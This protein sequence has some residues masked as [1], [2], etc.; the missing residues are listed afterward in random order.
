VVAGDAGTRVVVAGR[1]KD[2]LTAEDSIT[3]LG[4]VDH[5]VFTAAARAAPL[6]PAAPEEQK[7][8]AESQPDQ[9]DRSRPDAVDRTHY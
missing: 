8:D 9:S 5:V 7:H 1:D 6:W 3:A 2:A 4:T